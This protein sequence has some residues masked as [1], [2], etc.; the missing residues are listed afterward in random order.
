MEEINQVTTQSNISNIDF[1]SPNTVHV[2]MTARNRTL[3]IDEN[4][5]HYLIP[6]GFLRYLPEESLGSCIM[7]VDDW[8]EYSLEKSSESNTPVEHVYE[9][10][11]EHIYDEVAEE[12]CEQYSNYL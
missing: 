10:I 1:D 2:N 11:V 7:F 9:E 5:Q 8:S 3:H 12:L 4:Y 6:N